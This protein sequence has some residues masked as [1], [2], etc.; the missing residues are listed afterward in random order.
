MFKAIKT[1]SGVVSMRKGETREINDGAVAADLL[2][3]GYIIPLE[4]QNAAAETEPETEPAKKPG[5]KKK[6]AQ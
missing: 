4:D 5:R 1:F 2:K 6:A 3:A